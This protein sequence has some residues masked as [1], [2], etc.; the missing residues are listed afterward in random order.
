MQAMVCCLFEISMFDN[1]PP[2]S[3][4]DECSCLI[5]PPH[6]GQSQSLFAHHLPPLGKNPPLTLLVHRH[7]NR[8][9]TRLAPNERR[10]KHHCP[11]LSMVIVLIRL[12][13]RCSF[14]IAECLALHIPVWY[15]SH[16]STAHI[17]IVVWVCILWG[18]SILDHTRHSSPI[19]WHTCP[20]TW[21][22]SL[23]MWYWVP[24]MFW[25]TVHV[26]LALWAEVTRGGLHTLSS[27][28]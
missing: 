21:H 8:D 25:A 2:P 10:S 28:T 24:F 19:T 22:S 14:V 20:V 13:V 26:F 12:S 18:P 11:T 5:L 7:G 16:S 4:L 9:G 1:S 6:I 27:P 15:T 3:N 17:I 23:V